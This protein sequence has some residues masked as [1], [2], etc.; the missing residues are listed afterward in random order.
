MPEY[1]HRDRSLAGHR[2]S[3]CRCRRFGPLYTMARPNY[4]QIVAAVDGSPGANAAARWAAREAA[5]WNVPLSLV[6]VVPPPDGITAPAILAAPSW[7]HENEVSQGKRI[8]EDAYWI[9]A[10]TTGPE[11]PRGVTTTLGVGSVTSKLCQFGRGGG[12]LLVIG[13][14]GPGGRRVPRNSVSRTA[15]RTADCSVAVIGRDDAGPDAGRLPVIVGVDGSPTAEFAA[16][17]AFD[18][19]CRR[20]VGLI[21]AHPM[22]RGSRTI[23]DSRVERVLSK[24]SDQH[25]GV[26]VSLLSVRTNPADA[27]V[28]ASSESQLVVIGAPQSSSLSNKFRRTTATVVTQSCRVPVIVARDDAAN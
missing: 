22:L 27:I 4:Q 13:R 20:G 15:L 10:K 23:A 9:V 28:E 12:K 19:A 25:P 16:A 21:V 17:V 14:S 1:S 6:H 26:P 7:Q 2:A 3:A 11:L 24:G 8:L 18:E 5:L